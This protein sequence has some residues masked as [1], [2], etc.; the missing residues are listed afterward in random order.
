MRAHLILRGHR[1]SYHGRM[2]RRRIVLLT[3]KYPWGPGEEF[4]TPE[5]PHWVRD[6]VDLTIMPWEST[7]WQREVPD[8][9]RVDGRLDRLRRTQ[10]RNALT[11]QAFRGGT[12]REL[13]TTVGTGHLHPKAWW[14][15][16]VPA[17]A[18]E[19]TRAALESLARDHGTIDVAY[20]Y[21]FDHQ[22]LGALQARA[23]GNVRAVVSRA[24]RYDIQEPISPDG[25][26]PFRR[27]MAPRI[28]LLAPISD[29]GLTLTRDLFGALPGNSRTFRLGVP[30]GE[31][32]APTPED[33]NVI[34]LLSVSTF[35]PV[36]RVPQLV[37]TVKELAARCPGSR[38]VWCHAGSGPLE[39]ETHRL[40]L[41]LGVEVEWLGQLDRE[42]L[43]EVYRSR[44]WNFIVNVSSS[45][46]VPV[47]L[48]EAMERAIPVAAT[49][50]GSTDELVAPP[51]GILLEP[52]GT[53]S[54]WAEAIQ[55]G[56]GRSADPAWRQ[57]F[58]DEVT[59]HWNE[60]RNQRAFVDALVELAQR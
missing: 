24:H 43:A 17:A 20:S 53:P 12:W 13:L 38:I 7:D 57:G 14:R 28:D 26:L 1:A 60:E 10:W 11:V 15:T 44:P 48:M 32:T 36:K 8:G 22:T 47:S 4:I 55:G 37:H 33:P 34:H 39:A 2:I 52:D 56:L 59:A 35:T 9:I 25:R 54:Q 21:W 51:G 19:L 29:G 50:V 58:R 5:L 42:A 46:G 49:A 30:I 16:L 27:W 6:D 40:A 3:A 18:A 41:D 45:E 23:T 31:H